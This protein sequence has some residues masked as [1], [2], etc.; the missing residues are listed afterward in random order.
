MQL[1]VNFSSGV[2]IYVQLME[3]IKH[4]VETGAVRTGEQLPTIRKVAD[5]LAMNPNTVARAYRELEREGVIEVRHGSGAF[6]AEVET[7]AKPVAIAQASE[8]LRRAIEAGARLGLSEPE[9]RRV[10]EQELSHVIGDSGAASSATDKTPGGAEP[11]G[12][13]ERSSG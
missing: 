13:G 12:S 8:G 5:D 4:A 7:G 2:P 9:L 10:F 1:R 6:V 3:Q 11:G